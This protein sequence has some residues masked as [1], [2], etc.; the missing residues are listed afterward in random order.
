MLEH[1]STPEEYS[2]GRDHILSVGRKEGIAFA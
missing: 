2:A 1:L